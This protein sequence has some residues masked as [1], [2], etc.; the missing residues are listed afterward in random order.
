M[1]NPNPKPSQNLTIP[2]ELLDAGG[3]SSEL[4]LEV[5][6]GY[7][8]AD[9]GRTSGPPERCY[10]PEDA[11]V[12][13]HAVHLLSIHTPPSL[14]EFNFPHTD[15]LPILSDEVL[16]AFVAQCHEH[17]TDLKDSYDDYSP[18]DD[19]DPRHWLV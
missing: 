11:E 7:T 15:L 2:Y 18:D 17:M 3:G 10:P 12:E 13:L 9:P 14:I 19:L 5:L 6:F 4:L 8:P 16:D 1:S